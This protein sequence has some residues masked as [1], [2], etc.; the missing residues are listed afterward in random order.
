MTV[1]AEVLADETVVLTDAR[2]AARLR[3]LGPGVL[4]FVCEGY[5]SVGFYSQM[6]ALAEREVQ[7]CGRLAMLVDGWDLRSVDPAFR[8]SWTAWFKVHRDQIHMRLL[9]RSKLM[10]MA[11][12]LA[13][14]FSGT[15]VV[16]TYANI[17]A[18]ERDCTLDFAGFRSRAKASC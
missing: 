6:V 11:A 9:V 15:T 14:L 17:A 12:N 3:R 5:Y 1:A 10:V 13:N 18:W 8:E 2:G 4:F 16:K 7:A